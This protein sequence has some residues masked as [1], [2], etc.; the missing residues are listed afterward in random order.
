VLLALA[1]AARRSPGCREP[2]CALTSWRPGHAC[3]LTQRGR[4]RPHALPGAEGVAAVALEV[5]EIQSHMQ[6][7]FSIDGRRRWHWTDEDAR[8]SD[9][10]V[11]GAL[12]ELARR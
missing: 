9:A 12:D 7:R 8:A 3:T 11:R 6:P 1:A 10:A 4:D 5:D 2:R